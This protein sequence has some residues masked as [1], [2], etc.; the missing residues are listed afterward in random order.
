MNYLKLFIVPAIVMLSGLFFYSMNAES[1]GDY[2]TDVVFQEQGNQLSV[3]SNGTIDVSG[4][5]K[6]QGTAVTSTGAELNLLDGVT[7]TSGEIN[8]VDADSQSTDGTLV[9]KIVRTTLD[10]NTAACESGATIDLG[11]DLPAFTILQETAI[12]IVE[13]QAASATVAVQCE[14]ANNIITAKD[15]TGSAS[16]EVL[17]GTFDGTVTNWTMNVASACNVEAVIGVGNLSAGIFNVFIR[18]VVHDS[19]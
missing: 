14:D 6:L 19:W 16:G 18:Y 12:A 11:E 3:G 2:S 9:Q 8:Q 15:F 5:F 1:F 17:V 13:A 4:T 7:A 10:C